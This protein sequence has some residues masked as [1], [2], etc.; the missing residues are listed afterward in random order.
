LAVFTITL[1]ADAFVEDGVEFAALLEAF[2]FELL[3]HA[4]TTKATPI[5][6]TLLA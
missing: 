4:A 1:V 6:T 3:P 2:E 5:P